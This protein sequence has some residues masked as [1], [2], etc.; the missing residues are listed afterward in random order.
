MTSKRLK[1]TEKSTNQTSSLDQYSTFSSISRTNK[2]SNSF[3]YK[4]VLKPRKLIMRILLR[5]YKIAKW[6]FIAENQLNHF[7]ED[8]IQNRMNL[9]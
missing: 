3:Y 8:C 5:L 6:N 7:I 4:K 2:I 1:L 9:V